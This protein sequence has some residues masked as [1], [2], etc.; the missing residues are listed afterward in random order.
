MRQYLIPLALLFFVGC[1]NQSQTNEEHISPQ[2]EEMATEATTAP[3]ANTTQEV[4]AENTVTEPTANTVAEVKVPEVPKAEPVIKTA[5]PAKVEK[6]PAAVKEPAKPAP[7]ASKAAPVATV[8]GSVIFAQKCAS[9]HG[10]KAEKAALGK[11]QIIAGWSSQQIDD[12]LNGYKNG[13]Y[14]KEMKAIMQGQAKS[15]SADQQKALAQHIS[16]L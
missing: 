11:S 14:G 4:Q 15:L 3:E 13:T 9:C 8:D 16:T 1:N 2:S 6:A 7:E 5:P 12:A 10:S